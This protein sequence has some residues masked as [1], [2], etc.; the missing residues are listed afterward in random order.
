MKKFKVTIYQSTTH[1]L[2]VEA[3]NEEDAEAIAHDAMTGNN[4]QYSDSDLVEDYDGYEINI[5][6]TVE[7]E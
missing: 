7:I 1:Y 5:G 2:T 4:T 3:E 6:Q